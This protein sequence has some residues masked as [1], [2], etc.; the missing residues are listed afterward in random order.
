[1]SDDDA[2]DLLAEALE[3]L[4]DHPRFSLRHNRK[5][6]SYA[7]AAR[8][9]AHLLVSSATQDP[10]HNRMRP[11]TSSADFVPIDADPARAIRIGK[12]LWVRA[13]VRVSPDMVSASDAVQ[14]ETY[15]QAVAELPEPTRT[16][17]LAHRRDDMP[18]PDIA[19]WLGLTVPDVER[20]VGTAIATIA[21][22]LDKG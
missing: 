17:F 22:A 11:L 10:T 14:A 15:R 12:D 18:Y 13:W 5:R 3:L 2:R 9:E 1:M 20:H 8:I 4:N 16:I 19:A 7:L 21:G 6:T